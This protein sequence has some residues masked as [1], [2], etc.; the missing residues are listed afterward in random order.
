MDRSGVW[1][2][3]EGTAVFVPA[4]SDFFSGTGLVL[5]GLL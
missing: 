1:K 5:D 4:C 2:N 3:P